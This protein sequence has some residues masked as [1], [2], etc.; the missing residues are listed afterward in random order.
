MLLTDTV[1]FCAEMA[2]YVPKF[3]RDHNIV[4]SL[5]D[6]PEDHMQEFKSLIVGLNTCRIAHALRENPVVLAD[7]ISEFW[8][9]A[10]ARKTDTLIRSKIRGTEVT[11][12]EQD[13]REVL[14]FGDSDE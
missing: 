2:A 8:N 1:R 3:E 5:S 11:I 9:N 4:C 14:L 13:I 6:P 7:L 12:S 10:R